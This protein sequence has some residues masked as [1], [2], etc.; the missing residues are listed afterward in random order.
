MVGSS[1]TKTIYQSLKPLQKFAGN[2]LIIFKSVINLKSFVFSVY[3]GSLLKIAVAAIS[4]F[5][6]PQQKLI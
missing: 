2:Y 4:A 5:V 1:L 6:Y 3:K